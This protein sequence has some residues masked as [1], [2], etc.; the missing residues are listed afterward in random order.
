MSNR[1]ADFTSIRARRGGIICGALRRTMQRCKRLQTRLAPA[2]CAL[3]LIARWKLRSSTFCGRAWS[4]TSAAAAAGELSP[5]RNNEF[6]GTIVSGRSPG[7]GV[8]D[9]V[10]PDPQNHEREDDLQF[11]DVPFT[12]AAE[13]DAPEPTR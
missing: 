3:G 12:N 7:G 11:A 4:A 6:P 9:P 2:M 8:A 5:A 13:G 1:G 10:P